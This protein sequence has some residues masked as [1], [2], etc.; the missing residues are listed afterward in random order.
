MTA[1][2]KRPIRLGLVGLG[3]HGRAIQDAVEAVPA[4]PVVAV[5]D[6]DADEAARAAERFGC[7]AAPSY[8][9]LLATPGLDAVALATPNAVHRAQAEA[10]FEAGLDVF[11][12]KPIANTV[13]DGRAMVEAAER[14]GCVLMVGHNMRFGRA[15][16]MAKRL[17]EDGAIGEVVTAEVHFSADNVQK[18]THEGWR[19]EPGGSPLLPMMQL[20]IHGVDLVHYLLGPIEHVTAHARTV[21]APPGIVDT[22]AGVF[23]TA[24]GLYGT[25]VSSYCTPDLFQLRLAGTAGLLVLDWIPHRLTLLPRGSRT[26]APDIYDFGVYAGEDLVLE[27]R[28]FSEA[29]RQRA[30]PETDGWV[31]LRALAVVEAMAASATHSSGGEP[32]TAPEKR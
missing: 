23:T 9:A 7:D 2:G 12:E 3:G 17:I 5:F 10:A 27:L 32:V 15:A 13:A 30:T 14:A 24:S 20:G 8:D 26:E 21:L 4:L 16:R 19:F 31:G 22:V 25:V 1:T 18:G 11:V 28:A 6:P 29:V